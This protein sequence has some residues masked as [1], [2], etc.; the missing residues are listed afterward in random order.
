MILQEGDKLIVF[1]FDYP[2]LFN[3]CHL[4][5]D[6]EIVAIATTGEEFPIDD[7]YSVNDDPYF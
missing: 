3:S 6:G 2:L 4:G 7:I 1:H 5:L